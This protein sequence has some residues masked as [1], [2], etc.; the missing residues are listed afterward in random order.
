MSADGTI[1]SVIELLAPT[2][3]PGPGEAPGSGQSPFQEPHPCWEPAEGSTGDEVPGREFTGS[4]CRPV[5]LEGAQSDSEIISTNLRPR[6]QTTA[7]LVLDR[8]LFLGLEIGV[9]C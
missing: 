3:A 2:A 9:C 5:P 4:P 8:L 1:S 6:C 7:L